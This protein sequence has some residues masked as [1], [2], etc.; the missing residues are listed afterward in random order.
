VISGL[1]VVVAPELA[2]Q[3]RL[4][5]AELA[6]LEVRP[7]STDL[8]REIERHVAS[9]RGQHSGARSGGVAGVDEARKLYKA[10]GIDPTKTRPS[11]EAL[12]RRVLKGQDLYVVNTLV[13]ALNLCS[14]REQVPFGLYD[15]DRIVGAVSL[16]RGVEGEGYEGIR[17]SRV[18]VADRP[19]L[20]DEEGPFGNPTSDSARTR[21]TAATRASLVVA[22]VPASWR[23]DRIVSLLEQTAETLAR[24]SGG[25]LQ[26]C[27]LPGTV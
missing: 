19:V 24:F 21:I 15:R 2:G 4:G 22:Y 23:D 25:H 6:G 3:V 9:V 20:V 17:K 10:M 18:N 16:R 26:R 14:L 11:N 8:R 12:L 5:V 13:D 27:F 1:N 7:D